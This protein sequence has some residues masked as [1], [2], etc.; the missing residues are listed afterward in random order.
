MET[1]L[2]KV[3][4]GLGFESQE[5]KIAKLI[6]AIRSIGP[7]SQ[8]VKEKGDNV[9]SYNEVDLKL[10]AGEV[11]KLGRSTSAWILSSEKLAAKLKEA[12]TPEDIEN[13]KLLHRAF[14][15]KELASKL[16]SM[17]TFVNSGVIGQ[18]LHIVS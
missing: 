3:R 12:V 18:I 14:E 9:A 2:G 11:V 10:I 15:N 4:K 6:N 7:A 8:L 16:L 1:F 13:L 17:K 5:A